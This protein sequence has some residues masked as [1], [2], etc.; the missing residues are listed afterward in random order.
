MTELIY[1][2]ILIYIDVNPG[3]IPLGYSVG[4]IPHSGIVLL[5]LLLSS[6]LSMYCVKSVILRPFNN[7]LIVSVRA[8]ATEVNPAEIKNTVPGT[9][10]SP[11]I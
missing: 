5:L 2:I 8:M 9:E 10:E 4:S 6:G 11:V 7:K 1:F 3:S